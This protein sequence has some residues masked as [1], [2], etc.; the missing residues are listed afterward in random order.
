MENI[1]LSSIAGGETPMSPTV[2]AKGSRPHTMTTA[3]AVPDLFSKR[4]TSL[5]LGTGASVLNFNSKDERIYLHAEFIIERIAKNQL[6]ISLLSAEQKICVFLYLFKYHSKLARILELF[7]NI[8]LSGMELRYP[9]DIQNAIVSDYIKD[10]YKTML[11]KV[12]FKNSLYQVYRDYKLLGIGAVLCSDDFTYSQIINTK[13]GQRRDVVFDLNR[14]TDSLE[15][16]AKSVSQKDRE[17]ID[18]L[19]SDYTR[20]EFSLSMEEKST[21]IYKFLPNMQSKELSPLRKGESWA[22]TYKGLVFIKNL[23]PFDVVRRSTNY[24]IGYHHFI[25]ETD[26]KLVDSFK[27]LDGDKDSLASVYH[28][29]QELGYSKSYLDGFTAV[30]ES[31]VEV[32]TYPY[33]DSNIW[34]AVLEDKLSYSH[35]DK[36]IINRVLQQAI[37]TI[38]VDKAE[39]HKANRAYKNIHLFSSEVTGDNFNVIDNLLRDAV[40]ADESTY[41]FTNKNISSDNISMD[42]R[43]LVDLGSMGA[44]AEEELING[45]GMADTLAGG[46]DSFANSYLK[47]EVLNSQ[48][49]DE[50]LAIASF[51]ED[52]IFK[53]IAAKKGLYYKDAWGHVKLLYPRIV[54]DRINLARDS[55]DFQLLLTLASDGKIPYSYILKV[56]NFDAVETQAMVDAEQTTVFNA[57]LKGY[58]TRKITEHP[59]FAKYVTSDSKHLKAILKSLGVDV[60]D[61]D[62]TNLV[63]KIEKEVMEGE[64]IE[65][66]AENLKSTYEEENLKLEAER[67]AE[68]EEKE[69]EQEK[70]EAEETKEAKPVNNVKPKAD[71]KEVDTKETTVTQLEAKT[72]KGKSVAFKKAY[73]KLQNK[74]GFK[75]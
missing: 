29:L 36:S 42:T 65:E 75:K 1:T 4:D 41:I 22:T 61:K 27:S 8:P 49:S 21:V 23:D 39:R 33:T 73:N 32:G 51:V 48:F 15:V 28:S 58:V 14:V 16:L 45:L 11:D 17:S 74:K 64:G 18:S 38:T 57:E 13:K 24:D 30:N 2:L 55:E 50:R 9:E 7:I 43:Q 25:L 44:K 6:S 52:Q 46:S 72:T 68:K 31:T 35:F 37:T 69:A 66:L 40:N 20:D 62:L 3:R 71:T 60:S 59:T 26:K 47:L 19:T 56:L 10:F 53:P 67:L 70:K 54:F 5:N 12:D 34:V 63:T